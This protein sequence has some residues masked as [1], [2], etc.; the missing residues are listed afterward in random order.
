MNILLDTNVILEYFAVRERYSIAKQLFEHLRGKG[1]A[2][3]M[4]SGSFYTMIFL[5]DK[6]LRKQMGLQGEIRENALRDIMEQILDT[7]A[8]A[9]H[10][11]E[12]LLRGVRNMQ[13]KDIE[14]GCQFEQAKKA[15]CELLL[16]F[17]VADY[18]SVADSSVTVLSPEEYLQA[19]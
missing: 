12:S 17:N 7:I 13:F 4:S 11:K 5:V 9:E 18:P 10:D 1:D 16:T 2:L 3:F 15:S 6:M 14:D 8:V 19:C